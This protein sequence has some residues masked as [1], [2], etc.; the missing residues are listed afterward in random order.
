MQNGVLIMQVVMKKLSVVFTVT[1]VILQGLENYI[2]KK[3]GGKERK[4]W[5]AI[6][7]I[8]LLLRMA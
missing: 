3:G 2:Y 1:P 8:N 7:L 6:G 5:I 4:L